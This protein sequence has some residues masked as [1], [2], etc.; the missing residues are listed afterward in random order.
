MK[1]WNHV[2]VIRVITSEDDEFTKEQEVTK[3]F[4]EHLRS[5][6]VEYEW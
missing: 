4:S 5:E 6:T 1:Y 2:F 3:L